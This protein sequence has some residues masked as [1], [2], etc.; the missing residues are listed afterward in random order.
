MGLI[1]GLML[2][3]R[4]LLNYKAAL[5]LSGLGVKYTCLVQVLAASSTLALCWSLIP[6]GGWRAA[7]WISVVTDFLFAAAYMVLRAR[8][9][10][11][12]LEEP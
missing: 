1:L 5:V 2:F 9:E 8:N 7:A 12:A 3:G 4:I 11:P 10:P 6:R